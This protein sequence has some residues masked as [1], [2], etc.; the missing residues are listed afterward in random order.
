MAE[1]KAGEFY[2]HVWEGGYPVWCV[3]SHNGREVLK[4]HHSELSDLSHVIG[5][6]INAARAELTD[7]YRH[8]V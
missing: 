5:R 2:V 3:I 6:A 8:E 7:N 1:F 4:I